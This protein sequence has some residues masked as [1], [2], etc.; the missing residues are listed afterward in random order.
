M[1]IHAVM[2]ILC[3]PQEGGGAREERSQTEGEWRSKKVKC[4]GGGYVELCRLFPTSALLL[5]HVLLYSF[6]RKH[7]NSKNSPPNFSYRVYWADETDQSACVVC[8]S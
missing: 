1:C 3:L 7:V 4:G 6:T 2:A 5:L 8:D